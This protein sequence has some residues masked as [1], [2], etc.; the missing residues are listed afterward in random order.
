M[1]TVHFYIDAAQRA[2]TQNS[3]FCFSAFFNKPRLTASTPAPVLGAD[4]QSCDG[5]AHYP[6]RAGGCG[7]RTAG[8]AEGAVE[9]GWAV[10]AVGSVLDSRSTHALPP[11]TGRDTGGAAE[12]RRR[13][14]GSDGVQGS[15]AA[16]GGNMYQCDWSNRVCGSARRTCGSRTTAVSAAHGLLPQPH[17]GACAHPGHHCV[18]TGCCAG[19]QR[20]PT[21]RHPLCARGDSMRL[22]AGRRLLDAEHSRHNIIMQRE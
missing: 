13:E 12:S 4:A 18:P 5:W 14:C 8:G 20:R 3:A 7:G 2:S 9:W 10:C 6:P 1:C 11:P 16:L 15:S 22:H 21:Q 17:G 19:S